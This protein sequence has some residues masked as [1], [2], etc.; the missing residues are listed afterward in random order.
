MTPVKSSTKSLPGSLIS[1]L[2]GKATFGD[3]QEVQHAVVQHPVVGG[4]AA[5]KAMLL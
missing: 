5:S 1:A 4:R 2:G 3:S